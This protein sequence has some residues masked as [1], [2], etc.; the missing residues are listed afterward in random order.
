VRSPAP[1]HGKEEWWLPRSVEVRA[2]LGDADSHTSNCVDGCC[3]TERDVTERFLLA[4]RADILCHHAATRIRTGRPE[5]DGHG[6]AGRWVHH[7]QSRHTEP[8]TIRKLGSVQSRH[9]SSMTR[10]SAQEDRRILGG[11]SSNCTTNFYCAT[12]TGWSW[13][14]VLLWRRTSGEPREYHTGPGSC[15]P[16]WARHRRTNPD[17]WTGGLCL[18]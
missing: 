5:S 1:G 14:R 18:P 10:R 13:L 7:T 2:V 9:S 8:T 11:W 12:A 4:G 17:D 15:R 6:V 16:R 3:L